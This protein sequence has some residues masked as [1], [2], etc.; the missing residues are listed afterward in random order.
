VERPQPIAAQASGE[1]RTY[2][3]DAD[4]RRRIIAGV[5]TRS[6]FGC[7]NLPM[8]RRTVSSSLTI[9]STSGVSAGAKS[10]RIESLC[11]YYPTKIKPRCRVTLVMAADSI[12]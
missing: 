5:E 12:R 6:A 1:P 2:D 9:R 11:T 7:P 10:R 3:I 8:N 4:E